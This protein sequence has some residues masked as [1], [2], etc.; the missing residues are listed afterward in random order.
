[1]TALPLARARRS[2]R[3]LVALLAVHALT[4]VVLCW[5]QKLTPDEANYLLAGC[6]LRHEGSFAAYNTVL[7]G[8]LALWPNQLGVL[9]ADP[10]DVAAYAP[11]GRL[12]FV[13]FTLLAAAGVFVLA[14]RAAGE[15]AAVAALLAWCTNPLVLAHGC[16]MTADMALTCASLWTL[17][18]AW[19]WLDAPSWPRLLG[20]GVLLGL[21]LATKYLALLLL[22]ALA[23]LLAW[24]WARGFAPRLLW[25][26]RRDG[27]LARTGDAGLA[28]LVVAA[29]AGAT[30]HASYLGL[31]TRY[32][33]SL[34]PP[35]IE[36]APEDPTFGPKSAALA[37]AAGSPIGRFVLELL[38]APF[39]RG[40]DYQKSVSEG[41]PTFFGDRVAPGFWTYYVVAFGTKLP[42][43]FL[44]L[45]VCGLIARAPP[46]PT[47]AR[48]VLAV[49]V[50]VPLV[51]LSGITRLQ[52]GVRYALPVVP[53]F[54]L[55]AG[56]GM[57]RLWNGGAVLRLLAAAAGLALAIDAARTWPAYLTSFNALAPRPYLWF[58]DST[59]DW[60]VA[61]VRDTQLEALRQRWPNAAVV[62][63]ARGPSLGELIVHGEQ[64]APRDPRDPGRIHHWLRRFWPVDAEGAWF[65]FAIDEAAFRAAVEREHDPSRG[66]VELAAALASA[67]RIDGALDLLRGSED[68][69]AQDV[70]RAAADLRSGDPARM[71]GAYLQLGRP[72]LALRLG[73]DLPRLV[74]AHALLALHDV[75]ALRALLED[76]ADRTPPETY[77]LATALAEVGRGKEALALLDAMHPADPEAASV[78]ARIVRRLREMV[79]A[80]AAADRGSLRR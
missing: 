33:V 49:A 75:D 35:G 70:A 22:P 7:H 57:A 1:M 30:L 67:G 52:I 26:R 58:R 18:R 55:L 29:A 3:W 59:L 4:L 12:G 76:A 41:L 77:V 5:Q 73:T 2:R 63:G 61:G 51:F 20:T 17:E 79:D 21:A 10:A 32:R 72:D 54:C 9:V 64:L 25:S 24:A 8:P 14:R 6:I 27:W 60:R 44:A 43:V 40:V 23:V 42:L 71:G 31:A 34:P 46:W 36:V 69:G 48:A 53:W 66:R 13:P 65:A 68:P 19:R 11:Y 74:R 45:L 62:D 47:H 56:R 16:L 15:R 37:A 80:A 39:V 28:V 78:H 50:L 38:P